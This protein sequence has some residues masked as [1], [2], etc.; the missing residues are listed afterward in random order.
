[1]FGGDYVV[2]IMAL[3]AREGRIVN[4]A[5]LNGSRVTVDFMPVLIKRLTLTGSTLRAQSPEVKGR[6][7]AELEERV[8]PLIASGEIGPVIAASYPLEK[9]ALAHQLM[10]SGQHIGKIL[11]RA[12]TA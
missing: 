8:W 1:M 10:E 7:A 4:I 12:S 9:A 3:A 2:R 11:L 6:I 5:Y